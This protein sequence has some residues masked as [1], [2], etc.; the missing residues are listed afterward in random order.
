MQIRTKLLA[1]VVVAVLASTGLVLSLSYFQQQ[2]LYEEGSENLRRIYTDSWANIY[3]DTIVGME[4]GF[5]SDIRAMGRELDVDER[6]SGF[7][8]AVFEQYISPA[9]NR[10]E[11]SYAMIFSP[12]S[13]M[14]AYCEGSRYLIEEKPC[15]TAIDTNFEIGRFVSEEEKQFYYDNAYVFVGSE[16][17]EAFF[18]KISKQNAYWA[19][20]L[21]HQALAQDVEVGGY[22]ITLVQPVFIGPELVAFVALGKLL[23]EALENYSLAISAETQYIDIDIWD[24]ISG[25]GEAP[26]DRLKEDELDVSDYLNGEELEL[27]QIV[28]PFLL[29]ETIFRKIDTERALDTAMIDLVPQLEQVSSAGGRELMT[30]GETPYLKLLI[31]RDV[32]ASLT[33]QNEITNAFAPLGAGIMGLLLLLLG[34]IQRQ[35][36][37]PLQEAVDVL[38]RMA[39]G[40]RNVD[41]PKQTGLLSSSTDEVGQLINALETYQKES[42]ELERVKR[43]TT[44]LEV[45]RDEASE[46]NAAKSKFLA[47]MSHEL[48]TPLNGILG[49][50]DLLLE[51]AEDDGNDRM[52]SDLTKISQSGKHLLSL[53]NDILDL[54]K[55]EAGRME[56]YLTDFRVSDLM[57]QTK[58]ISQT[59]ADKNGNELAFEYTDEDGDNKHIRGDETRLRQCVVNLISNAVKFTENGKVTIVSTPYDKDDEKWL[60]ISVSDTGIG[61]T[62]EQLGKI[63]Q[64]Y[65]QADTSTSA[66]FGGTGLGLT[67]TTSLIQMMGGRLDVES[68]YG[69]GTTFT[70]HV[71]RYIQEVANETAYSDIIGDSGPLV[72]IVDDDTSTQDLIRRML[73]SQNFRMTGALKGS[74]GLELAKSLKPDV[75]LLDIYLPDQDGWK[76][77]DQLKSDPE[78]ADIPVFII[79]V[80][81]AEKDADMSGVQK[82]LH[83]PIDRETFLDAIREVG[84]SLEETTRV[85]VV[86]DDADA[87]EIIGRVLT[88]QGAEYVEAKNGAE[89]LNLVNEHFS[90]ITLDLDMPVMNGF[91][92]MRSIDGLENLK[93]IPIIVFSGMELD[94]EQSETV[95]AYTAGIINKTDLDHEDSLT[96]LL[97][98][99]IGQK[100]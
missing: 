3:T 61:M 73:K 12:K 40:E 4:Q 56:L 96:D 43:L 60:S 22:Y 62:E 8:P 79:S 24:F 63:L 39:Q 7:D 97:S 90:M 78:M 48:R 93:D 15:R 83:K 64:E 65:A 100:S 98:N 18:P 55:I 36:F 28:E 71:P 86:D 81:E 9:L 92:F 11:L 30:S 82:F 75:I 52:A 85:L 25:V 16:S 13:M 44:E 38:N 23:D 21:G 10:G 20:L 27:F 69:V 49:Y 19:G 37:K 80:T 42:K 89:A 17:I 76:V 5:A 84:I 29:D 77:L 54:S 74:S 41:M 53:I 47:N 91:E 59:L 57:E 70:I 45:A 50:A 88:A 6:F 46:A 34:Y 32:A 2:A 67:I 33:R 72:L 87:R 94:A 1:M 58:T 31:T 95:N 51:E 35:S 14:P 68:E 26:G 99:L 66:N